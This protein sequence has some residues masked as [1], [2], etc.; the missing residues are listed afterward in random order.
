MVYKRDWTTIKHLREGGARQRNAYRLLAELAIMEVLQPYAPLVV[1]TIPIGIDLPESDID[2]ICEVHDFEAFEQLV[3]ERYSAMQQFQCSQRSVLGMMRI[4]ACFSYGGERFEL[5]GQP[6]PTN[7]QNGYRHMVVEH[8]IL[9]IMG[10]EAGLRI[11][12]LKSQGLKTEPAFGIL[13]ELEGDP[14]RQLIEMWEWSDN[15]LAAFLQN[16]SAYTAD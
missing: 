10:A 11:K 16:L 2:I 12:Q 9:T 1:G 6:V 3:R 14:Y 5:F 4:V 13:L 15:R 7:E 8:K